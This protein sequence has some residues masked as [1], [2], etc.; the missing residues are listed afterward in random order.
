M[1]RRLLGFLSV[2]ERFFDVL[3]LG[4]R[5]LHSLLYARGETFVRCR[6]FGCGSRR[7]AGLDLG[8]CAGTWR[9]LRNRR[10]FIARN[11]GRVVSRVREH[12]NL[13]VDAS[14]IR[15][16]AIDQRRAAPR[17][18]ENPLD[19]DQRRMVLR[20]RLERVER[21]GIGK[22]QGFA[23]HRGVLFQGRKVIL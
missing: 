23:T 11:N 12:A 15:F 2:F 1:I 9:G 16:D 6:V 14:G 8:L 22:A 19:H 4:R 17:P 20:D 3:R 10:S 21:L 7:N 13:G 18:G 5:R